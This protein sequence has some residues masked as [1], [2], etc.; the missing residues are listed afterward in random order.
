MTSMAVAAPRRHAHARDRVGSR[1]THARAG[2]RPHRTASR[3]PHA[4]EG[5]RQ[6]EAWELRSFAAAAGAILIAFAL[7]LTYLAGS[8]DVASAGYGAQ[9]LASQRDELRRQNELLEL[10]LAR[11]DSPARIETEARRLGLVRV[12]YVPVFPADPLAARR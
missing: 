5:V 12:A 10:E 7:A 6:S 8:T 9:R 4:R 11:L 3:S 2:E 1:R